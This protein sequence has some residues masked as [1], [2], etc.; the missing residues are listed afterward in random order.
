MGF[1]CKVIFAWLE[2]QAQNRPADEDSKCFGSVV[3]SLK[4]VPIQEMFYGVEKGTS[5][6]MILE[7]GDF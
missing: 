7:P 2:W 1:I 4:G 6:K 5:I 3:K